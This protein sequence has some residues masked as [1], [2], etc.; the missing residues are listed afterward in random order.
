MDTRHCYVILGCAGYD[1]QYGA[2]RATHEMPC[3]RHARQ[4]ETAPVMRTFKQRP[5]LD[6]AQ[7]KK[8]HKPD[9]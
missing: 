6:H 8:K 9:P 5:M 3:T 1:V 2:V 7:A 4:A